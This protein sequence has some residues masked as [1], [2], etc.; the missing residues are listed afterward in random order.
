M[1]MDAKKLLILC[2]NFK[3]NIKYVRFKLNMYV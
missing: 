2:V 1:S 3:L